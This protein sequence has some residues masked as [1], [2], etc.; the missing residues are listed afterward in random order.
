[1]RSSSV[2]GFILKATVLAKKDE[3]VSEVT[4]N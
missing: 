3:P 4:G 2:H 1:M